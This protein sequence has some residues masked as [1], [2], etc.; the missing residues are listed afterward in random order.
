[1][2]GTDGHGM[3]AHGQGKRT[4]DEKRTWKRARS[5]LV[6]A[7]FVSIVFSSNPREFYAFLSFCDLAVLSFG[8]SHDCVLFAP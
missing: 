2:G 3:H 5:I 6:L 7:M 1:M 8:P 4:A